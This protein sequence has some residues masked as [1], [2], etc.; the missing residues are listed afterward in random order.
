MNFNFNF[1]LPYREIVQLHSKQFQLGMMMR[2]SSVVLLLLTSVL[3]TIYNT[4]EENTSE[5]TLT[6][7]NFTDPEIKT[8][9]EDWIEVSD[10]VII[11][12]RSKATIV[13]LYGQVNVINTYNLTN[14]MFRITNRHCCFICSTHEKM[15]QV[16]LVSTGNWILRIFQ[17]IQVL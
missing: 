8:V 13:P 3:F 17:N 14:T 12:G 7:L 5:T 9:F 15:D 16:S 1:I 4:K 2:N 6:L 11:G 10:A